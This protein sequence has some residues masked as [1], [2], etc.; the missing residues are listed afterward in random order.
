[1]TGTFKPNDLPKPDAVG[2][3]VVSKKAG[4][5]NL[6]QPAQT[7]IPAM[8]SN[9]P[10]TFKVPGLL[11]VRTPSMCEKENSSFEQPSRDRVK[12]MRLAD[13]VDVLKKR[14]RE[15]GGSADTTLSMRRKRGD[16][17]VVR[18]LE[19]IPAATDWGF[20]RELGRSEFW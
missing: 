15:A 3:K 11:Q 10:N 12:E 18:W 2:H 5:A 13:A 7:A 14:A 17:R 19:E 16:M 1:M 20:N 8:P 4:Q 9:S 6:R